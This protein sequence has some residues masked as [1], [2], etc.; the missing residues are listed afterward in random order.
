M[1]KLKEPERKNAKEEDQHGRSWTA[2]FLR[3]IRSWIDTLLPNAKP[4]GLIAALLVFLG[5]VGIISVGEQWRPWLLLALMSSLV[6][7]AI[8]W[9]FLVRISPTRSSPSF[10]LRRADAAQD[11]HALVSSETRGISVVAGSLGGTFRLLPGLTDIINRFAA[12]SGIRLLISHPQWMAARANSEKRSAERQRQRTLQR[13]HEIL[14]HPSVQPENVRLYLSPPTCTAII[15]H[16]QRKMLLNPYL[17]SGAAEDCPAILIDGTTEPAVFDSIVAAHLEV[18][19]A[20]PDLSMGVHDF[21]Q[22]NNAEI[23]RRLAARPKT[24]AFSGAL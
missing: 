9:M 13:V 11:M 21:I 2:D 3:N 15:A 5:L 6:A 19:W 1:K 22:E 16:G 23:A 12:G 4:L 14:D 8:V 10:Y 7:L 17:V 18:P 20:S 24:S